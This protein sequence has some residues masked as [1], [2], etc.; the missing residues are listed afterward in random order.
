MKKNPLHQIEISLQDLRSPKRAQTFWGLLAVAGIAFLLLWAKHH[1]WLSDPNASIFGESP[2]SFK[3]YMTSAWHVARD[4]D[5]V[6]FG[7]MNYPYG[8]H[9]LFTDMQPIV[10]ACM[11]WWSWNLSD[12]SYKTVGI[13]NVLQLLSMILGVCVLFLLL[14]KLH[15]PVWYGALAS[16][17]IIFLS[18]QYSR[19]DGH[20]GLS[21]TWVIPMLLLLLCRYEERHSRRYQSL[22][23]GLLLLFAAQLHFYYFGIGALF[24]GLYTVYQLIMQPTLRNFRVRISHLV[25]MVLLPFALLNIWIHWSDYA[26]DRPASPF[27]FTD[28]IAYAEGIFLPYESFPLYQWIDTHITKIRR[29]DYEAQ[30]YAGIVAFLATLWLIFSGFRMFGKDWEEAAYHRVHKGYLKGIFTAAF[31]LLVFSLGFPFAI[32]GM[33]WSVD[34]LGPLRQFRG[35]GRFTWA[36]YYVINILAFYVLWNFSA[37]FKGFRGGKA[38]WL[39]WV[40]ALLPMSLLL[41]EAYQ[42]QHSKPLKLSPNPVLRSV[43]APTPDHWLN[44]VDFSRF[45]ALMPIPYNHLGSENIWMDI[46]YYLYRKM[47]ITAFHSGVPEMGV[48]MSRTS[49]GQMAKSVQFSLTPCEIPAI[50]EDMPDNRPI[51]L[52]IEPKREEEFRN[53]YKHLTSKATL[54]Y[55][56]PEMKIMALELD[57]VRAYQ[58]ELARA[59]RTEMYQVAV[60]N[61][62]KG[63]KS[64]ETPRYFLS[65]SFDSLTTTKYIFQGKGAYEGRFRDTTYLWKTH[66]PKGYYYLSMWVKVDKDMGMTQEIKIVEKCRSDGREVHLQHEGMRFSIRSIVKGW[67]LFDFPVEILEDDSEVRIFMPPKSINGT[68]YLDEVLF[69]RADVSLY[70]REP[71]W[72]IR[73]NFWFRL[74]E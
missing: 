29:I 35:L 55:N 37:R 5:Y 70:R 71:G 17:G 40:I 34:Y 20:F 31:I 12:L 44:T 51:A 43:A 65:Q 69:K 23:I 74:E 33:E 14:R 63:W 15:L 66:I 16:L 54:V 56:S 64:G 19:F 39:R 27:G 72:V 59:M 25:V 52:M 9:A 30:H 1:D 6:H 45:Q 8:E 53:R 38:P 11:Q 13:V 62:D 2:D 24:L 73:N 47:F 21:H 67:A 42:F 49:V 36:F 10:S 60:Y 28:Y 46:D 58:R 41:Y 57:S 68:F 61:W 4:S 26:T 50:L 48:N 18:P 32:K 22:Q 3:N 7:G